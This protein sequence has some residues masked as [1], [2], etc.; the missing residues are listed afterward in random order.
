MSNGERYW[1]SKISSV[2]TSD[3]FVTVGNE[4]IR[5]FY[6]GATSNSAAF[7]GGFASSDNFLSAI[8][9]AEVRLIE[10][11]RESAI[12]CEL[13][14]ESGAKGL[15]ELEDFFSNDRALSPDPR[16]EGAYIAEASAW[17]CAH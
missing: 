14:V 5:S 17:T 6:A 9:V 1:L 16:P 13:K 3:P 2:V 4:R 7:C 10:F 11:M 8:A 12:L 15:A